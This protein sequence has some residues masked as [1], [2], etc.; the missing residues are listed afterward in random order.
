MRISTL[1]KWSP[2][3]T[4]EMARLDPYRTESKP[5]GNLQC[6][7]CGA[8][9][10][11]G[12]WRIPG[13]TPKKKTSKSMKN[14]VCPTCKQQ[15]EHFAMGVVEIQGDGWKKTKQDVLNTIQRTE[16]IGQHRNP[17]YRILS[18]QSVKNR[19]KVYVSL[20]EL[21]RHIGRQLKKSFHGATQYIRSNNDRF[22]RVIWS[23][24]QTTK[25]PKRPTQKSKAFRTR[26]S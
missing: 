10:T 19:V 25:T 7:E 1:R 22:L 20:P 16:K 2:R 23:S 9:N 17:Q 14:A 13:A 15:H 4:R 11:K 26:S 6:Q 5:G 8:I 12:T 24:N 21:A 18:V 3:Q